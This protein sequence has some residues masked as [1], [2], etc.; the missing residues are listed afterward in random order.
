[1]GPGR[2]VDAAVDEEEV[3]EE[4]IEGVALQSVG[5]VDEWSVAAKLFHEDL[6]AQVLRGGQVFGRA[7]Q[8][9]GVGGL[10]G[11]HRL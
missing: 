7:R 6:V 8:P 10:I 2:R 4:R 11:G 3:V 9:D 5:V 1:M